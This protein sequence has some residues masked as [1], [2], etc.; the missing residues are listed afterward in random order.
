MILRVELCYYVAAYDFEPCT[1]D[2]NIFI[3]IWR[4]VFNNFNYFEIYI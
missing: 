3:Y 1:Y 4:F 2:F